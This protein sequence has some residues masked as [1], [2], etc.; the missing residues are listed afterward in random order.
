MKIDNQ[1]IFIA[2]IGKTK[3]SMKETT[4]IHNYMIAPCLGLVHAFQFQYKFPVLNY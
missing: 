4:L 1:K 3:Q 2:I